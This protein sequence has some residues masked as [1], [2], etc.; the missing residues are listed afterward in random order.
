MMVINQGSSI[1]CMCM[2][3][4]LSEY[5]ALGKYVRISKYGIASK[6]RSKD[7]SC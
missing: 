1:V 2:Y 6:D 4:D 3:D 7:R 5:E